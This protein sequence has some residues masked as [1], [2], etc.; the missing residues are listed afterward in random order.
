MMAGG[1]LQIGA[2]GAWRG[3]LSVDDWRA[4]GESR[5]HCY[6][7]SQCRVAPLPDLDAVVRSSG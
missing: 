2:F 4:W 7:R 1:L 6:R 5:Q 3:A